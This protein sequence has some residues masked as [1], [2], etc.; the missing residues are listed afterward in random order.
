MA[1]YA[2]YLCLAATKLARLFLHPSQTRTW[3]QKKTCT[4]FAAGNSITAPLKI[5][6]VSPFDL[7][8]EALQKW[9]AKTGPQGLGR[10]SLYSNDTLLLS[11]LRI[12]SVFHCPL[13]QLQGFLESIIQII[14]F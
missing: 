9:Y 8:T 3:K 6:E 4:A 12:K 13:R 1:A 7:V 10:P 5:G 14:G 2:R 11:A